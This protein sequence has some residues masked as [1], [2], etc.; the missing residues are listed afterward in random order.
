[1]KSRK[2]EADHSGFSGFGKRIGIFLS[3]LLFL[4]TLLIVSGCFV[5]AA[6]PEASL[7]FLNREWSEETPYPEW[8]GGRYI[9]NGTMTYVLVSGEEASFPAGFQDSHSCV[10]RANSYNTLRR[11]LDK[12]T[13]WMQPGPDD[14]VFVQSAGVHE[15][16]NIVG[17]EIFCENDGADTEN[18]ENAEK[19]AALKTRLQAAF[20]EVVEVSIT[21]S[22]IVLVN[23]I[24]GVQPPY[25][26]MNWL[27][28]LLLPA[29]L[30]LL[31]LTGAG[32]FLYRRRRTALGVRQLA[33]G[34]VEAAEGPPRRFSETVA[35]VRKTALTPSPALFDQIRRDI[36]VEKG[37]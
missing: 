36:H 3:S 4:L 34:K 13:G 31:L 11:T 8:Y 16:E 20:G 15:M 7:A 37:K 23:Q 26:S 27:Y 18:V 6:E 9:E 10:I 30:T 33:D 29:L 22:R 21:G 24:D 28:F 14:T 25:H 35:A 19:A 2:S 12:L 5:G 32:V 1:M 17:V